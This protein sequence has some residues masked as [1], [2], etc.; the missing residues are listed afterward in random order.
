MI[1]NQEKID[2]LIHK[3][4]TIEFIKKSF[5]DHAEE[6]KDKYILEDEIAICNTKKNALLQEL[7]DLGGT[8]PK[9]LD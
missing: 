1:T 2:I 5:I 7:Q 9:G 4:E 3:I 6:F 8:W